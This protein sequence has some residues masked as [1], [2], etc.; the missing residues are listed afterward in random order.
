MNDFEYIIVVK[1]S[2]GISMKSLRDSFFDVARV[3]DTELALEK[4][5]ATDA[6][7]RSFMRTMK[8]LSLK[9]RGVIFTAF[10]FHEKGGAKFQQHFLNGKSQFIEPR[11]VFDSFD[12]DKLVEIPNR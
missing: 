5:N 12:T 3:T 1:N 4:A 11:I 7:Q 8:E 9:F 2:G 10:A 6:W